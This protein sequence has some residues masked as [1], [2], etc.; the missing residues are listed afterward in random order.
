MVKAHVVVVVAV[1]R[2]SLYDSRTTLEPLRWQ[3]CC[4]REV[5]ITSGENREGCAMTCDLPAII[6]LISE[7]EDSLR[8][9]ACVVVPIIRIAVLSG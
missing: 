5:D 7:L 2:C 1:A 4:K 3:R 8:S 6:D 9:H